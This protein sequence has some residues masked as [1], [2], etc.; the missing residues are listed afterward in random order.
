VFKAIFIDRFQIIHVVMF[1]LLGWSSLLIGRVFELLPIAAFI[2]TITGGLAYSFG[3]IF[4]V[5]GRQLK[6][7][8][9]VW[10]LFVL[11]GVIL[12]FLS[13]YMFIF[14]PLTYLV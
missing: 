7:A 12:H 6:Y 9:F 13:N 10:H 3:I 11:A 14:L 4:Y 8:H 2:L 1:L 5:L